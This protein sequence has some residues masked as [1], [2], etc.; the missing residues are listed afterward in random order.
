MTTRNRVSSGVFL[1]AVVAAVLSAV[2]MGVVGRWEAVLRFAVV[3]GIML[4]ARRARVPVGFA[5]AFAVLILLAMWGSVQHWYR[6]PG[7]VDSLVHFLTP[8]SL[9]AVCYFLLVEARL[10]PDARDS[11]LRTRSWA[12]IVWVATTG[13]TAAVVWE[14]YEWAVEQ[15]NPEGMI[16]GYTDTVIDILA[17]MAGSVVAGALVVWWAKRSRTAGAGPG[18]EVSSSR[19]GR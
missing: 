15:L 1:A 2:A 9:A 18:P 14:Y 16:V 10:L 13:T 11:S 4:L 19:T 3:A 17:G 12:P 7:E 5:A 6:A 8:G